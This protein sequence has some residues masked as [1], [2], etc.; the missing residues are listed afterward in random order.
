MIKPDARFKADF[1]ACMEYYECTK[2]EAKF[3]RDRILANEQAYNDAAKCYSVVA[4]GIRGM[5]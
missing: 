1:N 5:K 2:D 4:A 3:E